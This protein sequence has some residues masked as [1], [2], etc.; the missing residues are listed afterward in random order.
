M[1]IAEITAERSTCSRLKVGAVLAHDSRVISTGY[2]GPP[3]GMPHCQH[4]LESG[5][6]CHDAV[7]AETNAL[8]FAGRYGV[9]TVGTSLYVT[10]MPCIS[11]SQLIITAGVKKVY[12]RNSYRLVDG[13]ELLFRGG[14]SVG[15]LE[16]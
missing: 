5:E 1:K 2:N 8:I 11:C 14:V 9:P 7:H 16:V 10:H 3:S 15:K 6:P 13:V 4:D 12:Y